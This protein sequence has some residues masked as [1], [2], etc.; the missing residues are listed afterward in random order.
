MVQLPDEE[1][2]LMSEPELRD[3]VAVL[4]GGRSAEEIV[5]GYATTGA[6][7]DLKKA[8]EIARRMVTEF[9]MS[10]KVGPVSL[11]SDGARFLSPALRR[12]EDVS[13]E[14]ETAIDREI[15]AILQEGQAKAR[16]ILSE[17]RHDL[18]VLAEVLLEKESLDRRDLDSHFSPTRPVG[19]PRDE[20][21]TAE[22]DGPRHPLP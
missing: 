8:T 9:G 20:P 4:L 13:P 14:T 18:D 10:E 15:K 22:L 16:R 12:T 1:R 5:F 17:H 2:Y 19:V 7:D 21:A 3:R 11:A 6:Y